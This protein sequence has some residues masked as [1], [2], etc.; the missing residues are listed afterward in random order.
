MST[1]EKTPTVICVLGMSRTGTSLTMRVLNLAG[2]YLGPEEELL[3]KDLRQLAGEGEAVLAR[4]RE[5]NPE[6]FWEHYRLMRLNERVLRKLGGSWREP[7]ELPPGW[8]SSKELAAERE[9][10]RALL[11]ESFG[12]HDLWGWKDPRN[13]LTLPLWQALVP[14]MRYVICLRNPIDVAGSLRRR[15]GISLQQGLDLWLA[16]LARALI[17]TSGRP[18]LLVS[19]ES[20]FRDRDGTASRLARFAGRDGALSAAKA[21]SKLVEAVDERLWRNRTALDDVVRDSR[22]PGDVASL[23]L[24]TEMLASL[25]PAPPAGLRAAVDLYAERLNRRALA[26][27]GPP[28]RRETRPFQRDD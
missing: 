9:E 16:Y 25:P 15:D 14:Q 24:L 5:T 18:R 2:V 23:H 26:S 8:E 28:R 19:Y 13:C 10:A 7:P 21:A 6:G 22:V 11:E 17:N 4:A 3:Q 1:T 27:A 20:Y 12:G